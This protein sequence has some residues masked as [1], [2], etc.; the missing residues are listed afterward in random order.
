MQV[1]RISSKGVDFNYVFDSVSENINRADIFFIGGDRSV[2]PELFEQ[3]PSGLSERNYDPVYDVESIKAFNQALR[4]QNIKLIVAINYGALLACG[5]AGGGLIAHVSNH[6]GNGLKRAKY[7][8]KE[9]LLP[10]NHT[11]MMYPYNLDSNE[12]EVL[13]HSLDKSDRYIGENIPLT[14]NADFKEPEYVLFKGFAKPVLAIMPDVSRMRLTTR[15]V[16]MT[17]DIIN[18]Y[19]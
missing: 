15:T 5:L 9:Y 7:G 8:S 6:K 13:V 4:R 11:Q 18:K 3:E 17:N 2:S 12:Y 10:S 16:R 1:K 14:S 19:I